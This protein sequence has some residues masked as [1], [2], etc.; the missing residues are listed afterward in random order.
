[1]DGHKKLAGFIAT[2]HAA[3]PPSLQR[4]RQSRSCKPVHQKK[5]FD[6]AK[7]SPEMKK[8]IEGGMADAWVALDWTV[9]F[10]PVAR[11]AASL[12]TTALV[13]VF[14]DTGQS[15]PGDAR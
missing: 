9:D 14:D 13:S 6:P 10:I 2:K 8:P 3:R 5:A 1:M 11:P 12:Q 15:R 7:L 4:R